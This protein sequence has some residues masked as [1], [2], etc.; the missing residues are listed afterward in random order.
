MDRRFDI[1]ESEHHAHRERADERA[2]D[3]VGGWDSR[4]DLRGGLGSNRRDW[5]RA[6]GRAPLGAAPEEVRAEEASPR[7]GPLWTSD[8]GR[9][10]RER[11]VL[12]RRTFLR[13]TRAART[14]DSQ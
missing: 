11:G 13:N 2:S 3:L 1:E 5:D 10:W 12:R 6:A 7:V 14:R 8:I 9:T 4:R